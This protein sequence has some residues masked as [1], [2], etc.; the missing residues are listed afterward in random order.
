MQYICYIKQDLRQNSKEQS[1]EDWGKPAKDGG[2][3]T[4]TVGGE[5][6]RN[7]GSQS[8]GRCL[9]DGNSLLNTPVR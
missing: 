4:P 5:V 9:K 1:T 3:G 8:C 7:P 2:E 6:Y